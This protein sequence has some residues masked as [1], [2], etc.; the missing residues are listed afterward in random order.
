[1]YISIRKSRLQNHEYYQ[2]WKEELN[3]NKGTQSLKIHSNP[4]E[5]HLLNI[6]NPLK[7]KQLLELKGKIATSTTLTETF[8]TL[9]PVVD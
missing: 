4:K 2:R 3:N 7:K 5:G 9:L 1:M 8:N 6:K